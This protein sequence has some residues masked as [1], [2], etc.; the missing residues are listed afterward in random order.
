M[1]FER[2]E[3]VLRWYESEGRVLD[4]R[5]LDAIPWQETPRH[6]LRRELVPVLLY[7]RDIEKFT[8]IYFDELRR[9][10]TGR[11]PVIRAFMERWSAEETLHG[12]LLDRFLNEAGHPTGAR[13][14][15]EAK[16]R[17]PAAERFVAPFR[18]GMA[19]L[20]GRHFSAVHMTFGAI[21]EL[22][23]LTGYERLW[24]LAGHPVLE[25]ILRGIA[26]EEARHAFFYWN[27]ARLKLAASPVRR[28]LARAVVG[29]YWAPVGEGL[30]TR[31]EAD[32]VVRTLF[33]GQD[34]VRAV[35]QR[36]NRRLAELP[37]FAGTEA[38]TRRV[39]PVIEPTAS[40]FMSSPAHV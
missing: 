25:R 32:L 1:P 17:I 22:S 35:E 39:L 21:N 33:R 16:A 30:K 7:M 28:A 9:S 13:W 5:F 38:V 4:R 34:G 10:P 36:I 12:D 20:A 11:E 8:S 40:A 23:T 2:E 14:F 19:R 31:A 37:G 26:R 24:T 29:T 18:I 27:I 6:E 3:D 15:E